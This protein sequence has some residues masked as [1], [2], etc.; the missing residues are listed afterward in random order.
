[1]ERVSFYKADIEELEKILLENVIESKLLTVGPF[2]WRFEE[3]VKKFLKVPYF[4]ATSSGTA[5]LHIALKVLGIGPGDEVILSP[6]I[7]IGV[8]NV[9]LEENIGICLVDIDEERF[10]LSPG[11]VRSFILENYAPSDRGLINKKTG[12]I[13]KGIVLYHIYGIPPAVDEFLDIKKEFG[14]IILDVCWESFGSK[15][16]LNEEMFYTGSTFDV[17]VFSFTRYGPLNVGEGGGV[18][19]RDEENH[20]KAEMLRYHG[21]AAEYVEYKAIMGGFNYNL[22]ELSS[23]VGVGQMI[24]INQILTKRKMV[25]EHY[26]QELYNLEK[27]K[28]L[29]EPQNTNVAWYSFTILLPEDVKREFVIKEMLTRGV[30][31]KVFYP[32]VN[33]LEYF[34]SMLAKELTPCNLEVAESIAPRLLSLPFYG[35]LERKEI[36]YVVNELREVLS[37]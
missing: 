36:E 31:T 18:A 16:R 37:L 12:K 10:T 14:L 25:Y 6:L 24:R 19:F 28:V 33:K 2:I 4:L 34:D 23:A 21:V 27:I 8:V 22:D 7:H 17:G 29:N 15:V 11:K 1:M 5:A 3:E 32:L 30:P 9:L 20:R 35:D 13:L 26:K